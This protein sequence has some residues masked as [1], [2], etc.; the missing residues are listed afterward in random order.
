MNSWVKKSEKQKQ[1]IM[2]DSEY[3]CVC[4]RANQKTFV[5]M[6]IYETIHNNA[7]SNSMMVGLCFSGILQQILFG[8]IQSF[9]RTVVS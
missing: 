7:W 3:V 8:S 5:E 2:I 6:N 9:M 4:V 1:M